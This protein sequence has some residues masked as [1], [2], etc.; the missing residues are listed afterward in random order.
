MTFIDVIEKKYSKDVVK[1]M[2]KYLKRYDPQVL[3]GNR[4]T[5][6]NELSINETYHKILIGKAF[7]LITD[8]I[9]TEA[10]PEELARAVK[11]AWVVV[12]AAKYHLNHKKAYEDYG[13]KELYVQYHI[14]RKI[15]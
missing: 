9:D 15:H 7:N 4:S 8:M 10:S 2:K 1:S 11:Y 14:P 3:Y 5:S 12:D 13:I 6:D